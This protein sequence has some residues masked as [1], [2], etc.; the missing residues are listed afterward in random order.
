MQIEAKPDFISLARTAIE[1]FHPEVLN[2]PEKTIEL[3]IQYKALKLEESYNQ[4]MI[5]R[6]S[7]GLNP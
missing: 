3:A 2:F 4:M 7:S 1:I 6:R 5:E